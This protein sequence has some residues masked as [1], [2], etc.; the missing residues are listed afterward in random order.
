MQFW[1]SSMSSNQQDPSDQNPPETKTRKKLSFWRMMISVLQA[2]FGVQN[3]AN[4][5]RDF[6]HGS[7]TG[8][9]AAALVFT[10][11]FIML[12]VL[13]VRWVLSGV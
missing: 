8:F 11:I 10:L 1:N 13:L 5:E 12:L 9:I 7:I 3:T 2:S 6:E 4:K